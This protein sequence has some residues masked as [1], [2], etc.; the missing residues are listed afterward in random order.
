[1]QKRLSKFRRPI[2]YLVAVILLVTPL[3]PK[4]PFV[5]VPGTFVSIRIEDFVIAATAIFCLVILYPHFRKLIKIKINKAILL[6]LSVG[7][8]SLISS[9][10]ITQTVEP[11][12]G[13]LH[14]VRRIEY[15]IPFFIGVI[16][17]LADRKNLDF[18][19]KV[20][21]VSVIIIFLYGFGQR[22]LN[23]PIIVTQNLEYSKGVALFYRAGSHINATFAGHYDLGTYL[24]LILPIFISLFYTLKNL[25][26]KLLLFIAFSCGLWLLAFSGSRI[27][28][29]SYAVGIVTSLIILK[30]Y[31]AI[32]VILAFSFLFFS[33][34]PN[35]VTRYQRIFDVTFQ[36]LKTTTDKIM[37]HNPAKIIYAQEGE[38]T[39]PQRRTIA[40]PT[41]TQT[42]VF[43]DRSTSIR[44]NVE[45][46]RAI[47]ALSKNPLLGTGYSS[48]TLATD[49]DYLRLLGEVGLLGFIAFG[50]I[51]IR[52]GKI[53]LRKFPLDKNFK[54]TEL[55]F[56]AGTVGA[57][58][59]IFINAILLDVFEAS[60][61]AI[62]FWLI[63]GMLIT[64]AN[65]NVYEE[66][67]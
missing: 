10:L 56:I 30:K 16:A 20:I 8:I 54:G 9:I 57:I 35:L 23:F 50:L 67:Y 37:I 21:I 60:K 58:P 40:T 49:N 66:T 11:H 45:W 36:R 18:Y 6:F 55:G 27:S 24:V 65:P 15:F 7:F 17:I 48:I 25:K 53:I 3:Y 26:Y 47:R 39:V 61:F 28:V 19:I 33:L 32:P 41:P 22:Y 52:L 51:F 59:A 62:I 12:I 46:P 43:E 13:L 31:K 4:F 38:L 1:M 42:P 5:N 29:L 64:M 63:M 2:K 34:S 44:T 14:W